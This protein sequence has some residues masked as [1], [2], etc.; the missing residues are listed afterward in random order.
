MS[1]TTGSA[2]P[3]A[4]FPSDNLVKAGERA[5]SQPGDVS[6]DS[7]FSSYLS[8]EA[9]RVKALQRLHELFPE[10]SLD[11]LQA[12]LDDGNGLPQLTGLAA[13][14][15]TDETDL[16]GAEAL[17]ALLGIDPAPRQ[18]SSASAS[19][20]DEA[21]AG[22]GKLAGVPTEPADEGPGLLKK[23]LA[24]L[25]AGKEVLSGK[26]E[27]P[28]AQSFG[29]TLQQMA[30]GG[31]E[32]A[33][34]AG[35][36]A[37]VSGLS[38]LETTGQQRLAPLTPPPVGVPLGEPGWDEK[39]AQRIKWMV[40][41]SLQGASLRITPKHLGPID[42]QLSLQQ[43]QA[44]ISF[45]TQHA[46]VKEALNAA[47]PQLRDMFSAQNLQLVN[48]DVNQQDARGDSAF[49]DGQTGQERPGTAA[50]EGDTHLQAG[51]AMRS[52]PSIRIDSQGL[53]DGYA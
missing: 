21:V 47:L 8:D 17:F 35:H 31:M 11:D 51:D 30:A 4:I 27:M 37:G 42:I 53:F 44:S 40:G 39:L 52:G 26:P 38:Q 32:G 34:P 24:D 13:D 7:E 6:Q 49:A 12:L 22:N 46:A 10:Y 14:S 1:T 9:D 29:Q 15:L 2:S 23:L 50:R 48:V 28:G 16:S 45:T 3:T 43:D 5:S 18:P 20:A 41:N 36:N 25:P 33:L 19:A